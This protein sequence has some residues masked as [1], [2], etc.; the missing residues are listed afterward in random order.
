MQCNFPVRVINGETDRQI[1]IRRYFVTNFSREKMKGQLD[2][3]HAI[4]Q[5]RSIVDHV[6]KDLLSTV[7]MQSNFP[8]RVIKR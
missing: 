1:N 4:S 3:N 7:S 5:M 8:V 6:N 2:R